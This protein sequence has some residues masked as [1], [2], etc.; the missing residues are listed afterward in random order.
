LFAPSSSIDQ[1][2]LSA[3]NVSVYLEK[4]WEI[5]VEVV[6]PLRVSELFK[7]GEVAVKVRTCSVSG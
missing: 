1:V 7:T 6:P 5:V 4:D 3:F 2:V